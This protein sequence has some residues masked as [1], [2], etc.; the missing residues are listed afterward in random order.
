[1]QRI[2]EEVHLDTE[3]ARGGST[4]H[5]VRYVLIGSLALAILA[6]SAIWITRAVS[7]RPAQGWPVTAEQHALGG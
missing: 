6:M 2:G 1:M 5:I 7:E 3:E 4:P